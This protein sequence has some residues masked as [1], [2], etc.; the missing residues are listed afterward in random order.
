M[1]TVNKADRLQIEW[2]LRE[3]SK[4][5]RHA[6]IEQRV[7]D[8][9]VKVIRLRRARELRKV[10]QQP[11]LDFLAIGDSWLWSSVYRYIILRKSGTNY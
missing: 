5:A 10:E 4:E 6:E 7:R 3:A 11:P 1:R 2:Q 8:H 9:K